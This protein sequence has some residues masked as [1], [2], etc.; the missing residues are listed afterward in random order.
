MPTSITVTSALSQIEV[1]GMDGVTLGLSPRLDAH[2]EA[3]FAAA[4]GQLIDDVKSVDGLDLSSLRHVLA[5][6]DFI[7]DVRRWQKALN[8]PEWVT[9]TDG[10]TAVGKALSW[11]RTGSR[12]AASVVV[13]Q[14]DLFQGLVHGNLI[15][16]GILC[17]ELAHIHE[18]SQQRRG[19]DYEH[20]DARDLG[21][22]IQ[23]IAQSLTSEC[24]AE[25]VASRQYSAED[26][27]TFV[28]NA[29]TITAFLDFFDQEKDAYRS[30]GDTLHI[31]QHAIRAVSGAADMIGR[32]VG[33]FFRERDR[34]LFDEFT[35]R[36]GDP[37]WADLAE[38]LR[39]ELTNSPP[40]QGVPT[41][42]SDG[43]VRSMFHALGVYPRLQ[44]G[45]LYIDV[46]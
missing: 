31:W 3:H 2:T 16:R 20:P 22:V 30:H 14:G 34:H 8:R 1:E 23:F 17:H 13:M 28:A 43:T 39:V 24:F 35:K 41:G 40:N 5:T 4:L 11:R 42:I 9:E 7:A 32:T 44:D 38:R 19:G 15:A 18:Y 10:G 46:P 21:A 6:W 45:S 27:A 25:R 36:L 12:H 29:D 37:K 26:L 33:E